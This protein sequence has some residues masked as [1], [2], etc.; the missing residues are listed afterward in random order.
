M[1]P[2][3]ADLAA[4]QPEIQKELMVLSGKDWTKG[5]KSMFKGLRPRTT[6]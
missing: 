3:A 4:G 6:F 5:R 1:L 2:V